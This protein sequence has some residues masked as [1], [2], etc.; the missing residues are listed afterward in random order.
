MKKCRRGSIS[1]NCIITF[2]SGAKNTQKR[3]QKAQVNIKVIIL[4]FS[5]VI[6]YVKHWSQNY[7]CLYLNLYFVIDQQTVF[8]SSFQVSLHIFTLQRHQTSAYKR[9]RLMGH[10]L[11]IMSCARYSVHGSIHL[12]LHVL[13]LLFSATK[14]DGQLPEFSAG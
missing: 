11:D 4:R 12:M 2:A 5:F 9:L 1:I 6:S 7:N 14:Q 8:A 3:Q 10:A 13:F